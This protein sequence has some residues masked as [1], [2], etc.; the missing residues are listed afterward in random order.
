MGSPMTFMILPKVSGPTGIRMGAPVSRTWF[1]RTR[2][3]VP[4]MAMVRTVLSP[5][6]KA[7]WLSTVLWNFSTHKTFKGSPTLQASK[8]D[9]GRSK[10][11]TKMLCNLQHKSGLPPGD[12]ESIEDW[13]QTLIELDIHNGTNDCYNTASGSSSLG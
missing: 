3:S 2:P 11:L 7:H 9:R 6:E 10:K 12:F 8:P 5:V 1:P 13:R 4:S